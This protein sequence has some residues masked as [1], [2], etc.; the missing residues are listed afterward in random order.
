M[1]TQI[2][3]S[4]V[5]VA[6]SLIALTFSTEARGTSIFLGSA[7]NF[8]VL[9][10][11]TV[12]NTGASNLNGDLGLSPGTS[13]TGFPP[14]VTLGDVHQTDAVAAQAQ[15]DASAAYDQLHV[16]TSTQDLTGSNL[17]GLTLFPG[18]YSFDSTASLLGTLTLDSENDPAAMFI[19][20]IGSEFTAEDDSIVI[21][22]NGTSPSQVYFQVGSSTTLGTNA[23]L[24]GTIISNT[25]STLTPGATVNGRVIS[26]NGA[27]TL[28]SNTISNIPEPTSSLLCALGAIFAST[29]RKR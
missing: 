16:T 27:V 18:V 22:I 4:T 25:S 21:G 29:R 14:G 26:L 13:I 28:D 6:T 3:I 11:T 5:S 12:T 1:N 9:G 24:L 7:E 2:K 19:F 20:Q 17:G 10:A 15:L 23:S 8:A